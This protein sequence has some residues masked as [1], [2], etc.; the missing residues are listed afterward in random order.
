[1]CTFRGEILGDRLDARSDSADDADDGVGGPREGGASFSPRSRNPIVLENTKLGTSAWALTQPAA[2][3]EVEGYASATSAS[4][5]DVIT[6]AVSTSTEIPVHWELYRL[7]YYA[8]LGGRFVAKAPPVSVFPQAACPADSTTGMVE[9][10]WTPTFTI[11]IDPEWVSGYYLFKLVRDDGFEAYVP[12]VVRERRPRAPL[13]VQSNVATWQAYN[14][15]GGSSLYANALPSSSGF[16][17]SR[18]YRVS[19]DRPYQYSSRTGQGPG[20]L[21]LSELW[22][23]QW[24]E[25]KGYDVAYVTNIDLDRTPGLLDGRKLFLIAGHDEY[26]SVAE[27]TAADQARDCGVSLAFFSANTAYWR[28]RLEPSSSGVPARVITCYKDPDLDPKR[29]QPDVTI[30]WREN[31]FAQPESKLIGQMYDLFTSM[32]GFP[33]VV[34]DASHWVYEGTGVKNGDTLSHVVGYEWDHIWENSVSPGSLEVI[35]R[36]DAFGAYGSDAPSNMTVYY[37]GRSS[38]VFSAGTI[39]WAKGLGAPGYEDSR[40]ARITENM[41]KRAGLPPDQPTIVEPAT[42]PTDVG[43]ASEVVLVAGSGIRGYKDGPATDAQFNAPAGVAVDSGGNIY[44]TDARNHRVRKI[45]PDGTVS[46]LAGC[47][48]PD[49]TTPSEA[50]FR[51]GA[52]QKA[53]FSAPT[54]IAVG[55]D[56]MI[57]VSDAHNNRIRKITPAGVVTTF[58]GNG[59][60]GNG[61]AINPRDATF[62]Y[63]R[64][65]AFA[66][67]GALYV[68]DAYNRSI[69]RI[70]SGGVT[71]LVQST[72]ELTAVAVASDGTVYVVS[73]S[74]VSMVVAGM[75]VPIVNPSGPAGDQAGPGATARLRPSDGILID[76]NSLI[77]SDSQN[78]KV[79]RIA[80]SGDHTVTTLV[81]DGRGGA[82]LGTGATAHI[83]NP[84]GLALTPLG[85]IVADSGNNR[86]LRIVP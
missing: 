60:K 47:G 41:I 22:M 20:D 69:R 70:D 9:C 13:I 32:D 2:S 7:G 16:S 65:L 39:G 51:D 4:P 12:L 50:D 18:A 19:F 5:G 76:G 86:I 57:Y 59:A 37:P 63:P 15:W 11:P 6:L 25:M 3:N 71:T 82:E 8:G 24:L 52:G 42:P 29:G 83:E 48:S 79:R 75:L 43:N 30:R 62:A 73:D 35:A 84:R 10:S 45:A 44:V 66:P 31:P 67:D 56:G 14:S 81:G 85:Y 78:Y 34:T 1:M 53:C 49:R 36:S 80:L 23:L 64:G 77:V 28:I 54:G 38:I 21:F 40:I 46:T 72:G 27:R 74:N 55:P 61:D 26:W 17:A 33:E 58:A 68:A